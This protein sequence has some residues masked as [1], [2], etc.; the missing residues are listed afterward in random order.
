MLISRLIWLLV[1]C[2]SLAVYATPDGN[3]N[4]QEVENRVETEIA[5]VEITTPDTVTRLHE[6][7][8]AL[9]EKRA[10]L[11][12][13]QKQL[14]KNKNAEE[15]NELKL[16]QEELL[17]TITKLNQ[18]FEQVAT[19]GVDMAVFS[20]QPVPEFDWQK[21]LILVAKPILDSLKELTEKP[22]KIEKLRSDIL[23]LETLRTVTQNTQNTLQNLQ[24]QKLSDEVQEK[25]TALIESW[26]KREADIREAL[27]MARYQLKSLQSEQT[28]PFES[29]SR[30]LQDFA[31][32]R[33]IT[34]LI[35]VAV[36]A[37][38]WLLMSLLRRLLFLFYH[39]DKKHRARFRWRRVIQY[40][41][42]LLT[43]VLAVFGSITVFY[44]RNDV[45]LLGLTILSLLMVLF[46]LRTTLPRYAT[47]IRILLNLGSVR[48]DERVIYQGIP[49]HVRTIGMYSTLVNPDLDGVIRLPTA[50]LNDLVSRPR[51]DEPWFPCQV[52]DYLLLEDGSF[53]QVLKQSVEN[54]Q[55]RLRGSSTFI[56]SAD[57][58]ERPI[59]NLSR[60]GFLVVVTFGVDY[61]HQAECLNRIPETF[62]AALNTAFAQSPLSSSVVELL[63][64]FKEAGA[65]SL[66]YL[67]VATMNGDAASDYF[68]IQRLI[69]KTCVAVCNRE[70]WG[71]PFAQLTIHQGE[72]FEKLN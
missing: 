46:S 10:K 28:L 26:Q 13:I 42:N 40:G 64:D 4:S 56:K 11:K 6:I 8:E 12:E 58:I 32:G 15:V 34:L 49:Y 18:S 69:Q 51:T 50:A 72:G 63:V 52:G 53:A 25:L 48:Q 33:G 67:I 21:E 24:T 17:K 60:D 9:K 5:K 29:I 38:I 44:A 23:R 57:F 3:D 55:L 37:S 16:Q 19:G 41:I 14:V 65:S 61:R 70:Q 62:A 45:L 59:R 39:P 20:E 27:E 30:T 35:A 36:V 68:S 43:I 66:D 1:L 71:I 2:S 47:E 7:R 54:V 31:Q 22:R